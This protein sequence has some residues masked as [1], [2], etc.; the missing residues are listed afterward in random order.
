[1][2]WVKLADDFTEHKKL[3]AA[4]PLAGWLW[5]SA[6]AWSNR[7]DANGV[8]PSA[9]VSR[10]ASFDGIGVYTGVFSGDDVNCRA[11][12][13]RLVDV[14]LFEFHQDGYVIHDYA[15]YQL[16]KEELER[17]SAAKRR[18]GQAGGLASAQ[19]RASAGAQAESKLG[20]RTTKP[21]SSSDLHRAAS[22]S[23]DE[24]VDSILGLFADRQTAKLAQRNPGRFRASTLRNAR[25][26]YS[27]RIIDW[28][29]RYDVSDTQV[30]DALAAGA[31]VPPSWGTCRIGAA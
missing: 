26:D 1:M 24:R 2:T 22:G 30:A 20:T 16:T 12:A 10:L 27:E 3:L 31:E 15:D 4:G 21:S 19:A 29:A 18:A 9:Q 11:L 6:L 14:G 5:V 28:L 25:Q 8:I 13:E 17:R 7:N 23:D